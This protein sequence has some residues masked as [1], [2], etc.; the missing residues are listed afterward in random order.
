MRQLGTPARLGV[1]A[2]GFVGPA[3]L[4]GEFAGRYG[5]G[6]NAP[7]YLALLHVVG[8]VPFVV[9]PLLIVWLA[10]AAQ[11]AALSVR[12]Y[13]PYP[14]ADALPPRGPVRRVLRRTYLA[15]HNRRRGRG[16]PPELPKALEG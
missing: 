4:L 2:I 12:R 10:G 13:G 5:L 7:W 6:W 15:V 11:L 3:L 9:V 14:E 1:L 16:A 8:Y